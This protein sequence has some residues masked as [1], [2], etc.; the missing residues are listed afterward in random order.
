MS[1]TRSNSRCLFR[2]VCLSDRGYPKSWVRAKLRRS[3]FG[4]ENTI[5]SYTYILHLLKYLNC[6]G[7]QELGNIPTLHSQPQSP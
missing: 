4:E 5:I 2:H 7:L 6:G 3:Y 1:F